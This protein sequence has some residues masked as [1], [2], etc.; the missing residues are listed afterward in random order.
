MS[1]EGSNLQNATK[2]LKIFED[3]STKT[4]TEQSMRSQTALI[5]VMEFTGC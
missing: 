2:M 4:V 5:S 3:S 1:I